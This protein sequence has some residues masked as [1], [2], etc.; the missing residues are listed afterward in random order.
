M[1]TPPDPAG[2]AG[3]FRRLAAFD[4]DAFDEIAARFRGRLLKVARHRLESE[5]ELRGLYDEEDAFQSAM[6]LMWLCILEGD[7][8]PPGG[9][10]DFLRPART[11]IRRGQKRGQGKKRGQAPL[12]EIG[13]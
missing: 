8:A 7:M 6:G 13:S 12:S 2:V 11:I 3:P 9:V 4:R 1:D 5:P 10:D